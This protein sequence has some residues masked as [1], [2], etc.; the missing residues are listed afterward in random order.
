MSLSWPAPRN[1]L[2]GQAT[3]GLCADAW[4][5]PEPNGS[6]L[7]PRDSRCRLWPTRPCLGLGRGVL[8]TPSDSRT[9]SPPSFRRA[10][11]I[12]SY[13][14][15]TSLRM[16]VLSPFLNDQDLWGRGHGV[17]FLGGILLGHEYS[18]NSRRVN[19]PSGMEMSSH[20]P[21]E[22]ACRDQIKQKGKM[23]SINTLG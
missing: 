7:A 23:S 11:V 4:C 22:T 12:A 10:R 13:W 2:Q 19:R 14:E 3:L 20:H 18:E 15:V 8:L 5:W 9:L 1:F 21:S 17:V 16:P 6:A